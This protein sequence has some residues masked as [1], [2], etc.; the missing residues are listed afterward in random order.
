MFAVLFLVACVGA[1]GNGFAQRNGNGNGRGNGNATGGGNPGVGNNG[2]DKDVGNGAK[3]KNPP[4]PVPDPIGGAG[5]GGTGGGITGDPGPN[6]GGGGGAGGGNTGGGGAGNTGGGNGGSG[7]ADPTPPA[8]QDRADH[9]PGR[10]G[11]TRQSRSL[12]GTYTLVLAGAYS[13]KGTAKVS[14]N[15]LAITATVTAPDGSTGTLTGA[16]LTING[17]YFAGNATVIGKT[18]QIS[19]RL[20]AEKASRLIADFKDPAG[21]PGRIVGTLESSDEGGL[22]NPNATADDD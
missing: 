5:N 13:G 22:A 2:N 1:A 18:I 14:E 8:G 12:N 21:K 19:G 4:A 16:S 10:N 6:G 7:G 9:A 20:D 11:R 15:T 3:D 17:P